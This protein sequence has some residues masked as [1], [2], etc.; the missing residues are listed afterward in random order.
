MLCDRGVDTERL[1]WQLCDNDAYKETHR[2]L[3]DRGV[4]T[5]RLTWQQCD[6]DDNHMGGM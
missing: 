6:N 2:V 1:T 3:C 4:D 5:E